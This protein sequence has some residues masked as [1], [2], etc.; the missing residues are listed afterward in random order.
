MINIHVIMMKIMRMI[1]VS[2]FNA[3]LEPK[4]APKIITKPIGKPYRKLTSPNAKNMAS[5]AKLDVKLKAFALP[6]ACKKSLPII[7][8]KKMKN[9]PVPGPKKPS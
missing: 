7:N 2:R 8:S 3:N 1:L 5:A 9:E 6:A 4:I